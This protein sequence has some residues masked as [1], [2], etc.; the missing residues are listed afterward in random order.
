MCE[1]ELEDLDELAGRGDG[2]VEGDAVALM[3]DGAAGGL[4]EDVGGG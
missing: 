4:E 2:V 1:E 3:E